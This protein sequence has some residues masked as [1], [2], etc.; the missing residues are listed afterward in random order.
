[1]GR[2]RVDGK[3]EDR[4]EPGGIVFEHERAL[5]EVRNRL[6]EGQAEARSVIGP[7]RI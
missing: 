7:A 4:Q 3:L 2:L 6:G 1:M 5:V